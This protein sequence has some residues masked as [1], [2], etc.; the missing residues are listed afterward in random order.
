M[1]NP[2]PYCDDEEAQ[3]AI[4][5]RGS[6]TSGQQ[7]VRISSESMGR[8]IWRNPRVQLIQEYSDDLILRTGTHSCK[9]RETH[10]ILTCEESDSFQERFQGVSGSEEDNSSEAIDINKLV[11]Q[12]TNS[13]RNGHD[14]DYELAED[15]VP[16]EGVKLNRSQ[17]INPF[18]G[19]KVEKVELDREH[20]LLDSQNSN[21]ALT[22]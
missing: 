20:L 4:S 17:I 7:D 2:N 15:D 18:G 6:S 8:G 13:E 9:M 5:R 3:V 22:F 12:N 14:T 11:T 19:S 21:I 1:N 16:D 10:Q